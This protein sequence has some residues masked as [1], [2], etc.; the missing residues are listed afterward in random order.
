[1]IYE[2]RRYEV[3]PGRI[4]DLHARF[5]DHTL[6][7]F[8]KHGLEVVVMWNSVIGE[9][10]NCLT[11]VLKFEDLASREKAWAS[12][13]ADEEWKQVFRESNKNGQIVIK[14]DNKIFSPTDYSP[15]P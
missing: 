3:A 9:A 6:E 4:N 5:R 2:Y 8:R 11:Y 13:L 14:V 15:V 7:L 1:M 12:F 10:T